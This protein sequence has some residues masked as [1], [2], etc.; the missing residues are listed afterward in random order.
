MPGWL[1]YVGSFVV[2]LGVIIF[3]H[4]L[5][6]FMAAK[7]VGIH[8]HRFSLGIGPPIRWLTARWGDTEYCIAWLPLGGYVK[9]AGLG[10][11]GAMAQAEGGPAAGWDKVPPERTFDH[12]P[13]PARALVISAG[14]AMNFLFAFGVYTVLAG[15]VGRAMEPTTRV[16]SVIPDSLPERARPLLTLQRGDRITAVN[17]RPVA[18]WN[19]IEDAFLGGGDSLVL[20]IEGKPALT[21][22]IPGTDVEARFKALISLAPLHAAVVGGVA[23]G[24]PASRAGI[25]PGDTVVAID[26]DTVRS[27]VHMASFI[28]PRAGDTLTVALLKDGVVREVRVVPQ[29]GLG[30]A[31]GDTAAVERG[32]IGVSRELVIERV[33]EPPLGAI[34][35]GAAQTVTETARV[36]RLLKGIVQRHVSARQLGGPIMIGQVSGQFARLGLASFVTFMALLSIN[37]AILNL[38]PIPVLDGGHLVFLGIEAVRR[39][40]LTPKV[41]GGLEQVGLFLLAALVLWAFWNDINRLVGG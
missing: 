14:V 22:H 38:L 6:H 33:R 28:Q 15:T 35:A 31:P 4:E 21:L 29:A 10:D 39:R 36:L 1:L 40:P 18:A 41:R 37:I 25:A 34:R 5:G 9:M 3:V 16:D 32:A 20:G 30:A 2:V 7:A 19:D 8:V 12:K 11:E 13:L 24:S 27:W 26:G 17:A 23:P